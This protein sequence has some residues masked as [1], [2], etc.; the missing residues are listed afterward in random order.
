[1]TRLDE[2]AP[3]SRDISEKI[4]PQPYHR[5]DILRVVIQTGQKIIGIVDYRGSCTWQTS[6]S[7]AIRRSRW[8]AKETRMDMIFL[9]AQPF[10]TRKPKHV[11]YRFKSCGSYLQQ[12]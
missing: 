10:W 4:H 5:K 3:F 11:E 8:K 9:K 7:P 1:M 12:K 6:F 2:L